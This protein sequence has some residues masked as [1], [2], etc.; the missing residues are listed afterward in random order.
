[1]AKRTNSCHYPHFF[2]AHPTPTGFY[3][4]AWGRRDNG[5]PE[6]KPVFVSGKAL[7]EWHLVYLKSSRHTPCA[8]RILSNFQG[9]GTWKVPATL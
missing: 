5:A 2:H 1:M 8:L 6:E 3:N 9:Y 7:A 4:K